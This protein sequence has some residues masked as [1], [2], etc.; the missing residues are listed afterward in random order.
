MD[1]CETHE[2]EL[3]EL[4]LSV[5]TK[6]EPVTNA[7]LGPWSDAHDAKVRGYEGNTATIRRV[8]ALG[9]VRKLPRRSRHAAAVPAAYSLTL[10]PAGHSLHIYWHFAPPS[11]SLLH[12]WPPSWCTTPA[13]RCGGLAQPLW[14][15]SPSSLLCT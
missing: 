11:T 4:C 10:S 7:L 12:H 14:Q 13:A 8:R 3:Q 6:T 5:L 1:W 9:V 2:S 15:R